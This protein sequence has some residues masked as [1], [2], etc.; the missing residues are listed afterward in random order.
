MG[1]E[2]DE[3]F[4]SLAASDAPSD[5]YL[6]WSRVEN[7]NP[8]VFSG[9][10]T[11]GTYEVRY[12]VGGTGKVLASSSIEVLEVPITLNAPASVTA[13]LRFEVRWTGPAARGDYLAITRAKDA[14]HRYL[15][16][17]TTAS[18]SPTSLAAPTRP[19]SYQV[20]YVRGSGREVAARVPIEVVP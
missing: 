10:G 6:Q 4:V 2:G 18:G 12:V 20:R 7:G 14:A 1:P 9:P 3:D 11:P 8:A 16:W 19:G 13:G 5:D 17:A 15:D